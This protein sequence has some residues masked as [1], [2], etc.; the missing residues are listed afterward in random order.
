MNITGSTVFPLAEFAPY[1]EEFLGRQ[2]TNLEINAILERVTKKYRDNGYF[3]SSATAPP[4][5]LSFGIVSIQ[6]T[7]GYI[8]RVKYTGDKPGR[9]RLF[10]AWAKRITESI[11]AKLPEI[12]RYI[13]LISDNPG[14]RAT[15]SLDETVAGEGAYE[16][17][18]N[19]VRD[20]FDFSSG[21]DNRGTNPVGP[22]Q[23]SLSGGVNS[24][25]G[26]LERTRLSV[27]TVPDNPEE[28]L[29]GEIYSQIPITSEGT[30]IWA[31]ASR[32][33]VDIYSASRG[34]DLQSTGDRLAAGL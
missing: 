4:Q 20:R 11:P 34:S 8:E 17:T 27:F 23:W 14:V 2:I 21:I 12:E 1:Y 24:L 3:L 32:S 26:G 30:Q 6:M 13:L 25:L 7:E 19:L 22:L 31:S 15:P 9:P 28:L 10:D 33:K 18:I 5:D 16:M 29:Y